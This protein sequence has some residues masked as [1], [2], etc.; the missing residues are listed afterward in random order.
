MTNDIP[1]NRHGTSKRFTYLDVVWWW[2][3]HL[4]EAIPQFEGD[5]TTAS[6][7]SLESTEL[8]EMKFLVNGKRRLAIVFDVPNASETQLVLCG[9]ESST[10]FTL[11][12]EHILG[13]GVSSYACPELVTYPNSLSG[14]FAYV[15]KTT[16]RAKVRRKN[17]VMLLTELSKRLAFS[18][19]AIDN[20]ATS[21]KP[22]EIT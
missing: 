10:R 18:N 9:G 14:A 13:S 17:E 2:K 8:K 21:H 15:Q 16:M 3:L 20:K 4:D 5:N 12:L 19:K 11:E 1:Q 7:R 6:N 22:S